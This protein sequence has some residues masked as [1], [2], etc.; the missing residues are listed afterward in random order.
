M[1][2]S[3]KKVKSSSAGKKSG[4][5]SPR[6]KKAALP[7]AAN[8]PVTSL[9]DAHKRG[10]IFTFKDMYT[11]APVNIL[12]ATLTSKSGVQEGKDRGLAP[13]AHKVVEH[14]VYVL[15]FDL[16]AN[17]AHRTG[18][19]DKDAMVALQLMPLAYSCNPSRVRNGA[20]VTIRG[21]WLFVHDNPLY[22]L[23]PTEL[24]KLV[25]PTLK[26]KE[27]KSWEDYQSPKLNKVKADLAQLTKKVTVYDLKTKLMD[28][29]DS[30]QEILNGK[31]LKRCSGCLIIE[32]D[33]ANLNGDPANAG[34]PR[35]NSDGTGWATD[36]SFKRKL[37][38]LVGEKENE[39]V[40][41]QVRKIIKISNTD[42]KEHYQILEKRDRVRS[43]VVKL[44]KTG[45]DKFHYQNW[46][47]RLFGNTFL[48]KKV[49]E[50]PESIE[51]DAE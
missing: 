44:I 37:R 45:V 47:A 32:V 46:D 30:I 3:V 39:S 12:E 20:N 31:S 34:S 43:E 49:E 1:K 23:Q 9:G 21:F 22:S 36:V 41:S 16:N 38:D 19:T 51:E 42:D 18:A 8:I 2:K 24:M 14:G 5:K 40:W 29:A 33:H 15:E 6:A 28:D 13:Q 35:Q 10:G 4:T 50:T 27:P 17:L 25:R 11:L 48:D 26:N 7:K